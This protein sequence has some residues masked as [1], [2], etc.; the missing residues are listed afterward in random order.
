MKVLVV[1]H[2]I[3]QTKNLEDLEEV[4]HQLSLLRQLL[5]QLL[6]PKL[7]VALQQLLQLHLKLPGEWKLPSHLIVEESNFFHIQGSR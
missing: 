7:K 4:L 2:L 5:H 3:R 1:P 6:H